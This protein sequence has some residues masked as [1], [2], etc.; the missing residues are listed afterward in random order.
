MMK[1]FFNDLVAARTLDL[2]SSRIKTMSRKARRTAT[3]CDN[4]Y[5]GD[6]CPKESKG[7][8]K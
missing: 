8:D 2:E 3:Y 4:H 6:G 5:G 1:G 7:N